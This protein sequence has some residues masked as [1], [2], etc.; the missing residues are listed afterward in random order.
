MKTAT[1]SKWPAEWVEM[2]HKRETWP[3]EGR[4]VILYMAIDQVLTTGVFTI[5]HIDEVVWS[6][7]YVYPPGTV[8]SRHWFGIDTDGLEFS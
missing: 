8:I 7:D 4:K 1:K 5:G 2:T 6:D 3:D